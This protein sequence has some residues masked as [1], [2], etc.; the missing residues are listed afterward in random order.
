MVSTYARTGFYRSCARGN[1]KPATL[2]PRARRWPISARCAPLVLKQAAGGGTVHRGSQCLDMP[3]VHSPTTRPSVLHRV[4]AIAALPLVFLLSGCLRVESAMTVAPDDT[5]S[6]SIVQ[7]INIAA[8]ESIL[9][10][11]PQGDSSSTE[12]GKPQ[13]TMAESMRRQINE[14]VGE[15]NAKL[16]DEYG[17]TASLYEQDPWMGVAISFENVPFAEFEQVVSGDAFKAVEGSGATDAGVGGLD[18]TSQ[19]ENEFPFQV[20]FSRDGDLQKVSGQIA[21]PEQANSREM[22]G[23][24][25]GM[26]ALIPTAALSITFSGEILETNGSV[27]GSTVTWET[28]IGTNIDVQATATTGSS[29]IQLGGLIKWL[30]LLL[31]PVGVYAFLKYRRENQSS[32]TGSVTATAAYQ[33]PAEAAPPVGY[34]TAAALADRP[35]ITEEDRVRAQ[36]QPNSWL[37]MADPAWGPNPPVEGIK[38]AYWVDQYGTVTDAWED[39][40]AYKFPRA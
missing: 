18:A 24:A 15:A 16:P 36:G 13:E 4:A 31:I 32:P 1:I 14:S 19:Q 9:G 38:G 34:P 6:G 27:Q 17:L 8:M 26:E 28:P 20:T 39:N 25:E 7:K 10:G 5:I 3:D 37:Y 35:P 30:P 21:T 33:P 23:S 22:T 2:P 12:D 29:G 11:F 40:P